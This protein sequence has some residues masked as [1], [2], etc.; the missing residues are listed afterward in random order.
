MKTVWLDISLLNQEQTCGMAEY[1]K[2]I[3][4][5]L[6]KKF[7][8]S[9]FS[10]PYKNFVKKGILYFLWLN[11]FFYIKTII[12]KPD[13]IIFPFYI[14][15]FFIRKKT[16]YY[17]VFHDLMLY[18]ENFFGEKSVKS[19]KLKM[20]I[21]NKKATKIITVSNTSK[22][23]I[24]DTF[25]ISPD[26]VAVAYN[27]V[28]NQF[29]NNVDNSSD[30]ISDL[31]NLEP[32]KYIF[33][34]AGGFKHKNTGALI[35]AFNLIYEKYPDLKLV[36]AG[37]KGNIEYKTN[38][39]NPNIIFAGYLK[40]E[41]LA[42]LYKNAL[43]FVLPSLEEGFGIPIIEAQYAGIPVLCSDIPIFQ[44]VVEN[45]AELCAPNSHGIAQKLELLLSSPNRLSELSYLGKNNEKR[46]L[47]SIVKKQFI[48]I[49]EED[50]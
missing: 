11:S 49:L 18:R 44:E 22:K 33:S 43:I 21:A 16:K 40:N 10:N 41:E 4:S 13:I 28:S 5:F 20:N 12:Q 19:F 37:Y 9:T 7:L 48:D 1:T 32:K 24:C 42:K 34:L 27:I 36:L 6:D 3:K 14:M 17:V 39:P 50:L 8:V 38:T 29:K 31:F 26:R 15:P 46:F 35:D 23:A 45:S 2:N 30:N 47:H 25:G